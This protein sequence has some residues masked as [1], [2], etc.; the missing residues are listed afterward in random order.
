MTPGVVIFYNYVEV[1]SIEQLLFEIMLIPSIFA[2]TG[3]LW[4]DLKVRAA[5]GDRPKLWDWADPIAAIVG[6][7]LVAPA[8]YIAMPDNVIV[9]AMARLVPL[10]FGLMITF[11]FLSIG[12]ECEGWLSTPDSLDPAAERIR[13]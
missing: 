10:L 3:A 5:R 13:E 1:M 6:T 11:A 9:R 4:L 2:L 8:V 7:L 12:A